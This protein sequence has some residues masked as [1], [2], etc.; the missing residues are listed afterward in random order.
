MDRNG[1]A[2][3]DFETE[4]RERESCPPLLIRLVRVRLCASLRWTERMEVDEVATDHVKNRWMD[5]MRGDG[6]DGRLME[7]EM[8]NLGSSLH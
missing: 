1:R 5:V 2:S 6:F 3:E 7:L 8:G 4:K